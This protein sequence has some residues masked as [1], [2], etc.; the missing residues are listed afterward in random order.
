MTSAQIR[1]YTKK[2]KDYLALKTEMVSHQAII[3]E[4]AVR[5]RTFLGLLPDAADVR[6]DRPA[7]PSDQ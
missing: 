1:Y 2:L 7:G 4:V 5:G 3:K 6:P